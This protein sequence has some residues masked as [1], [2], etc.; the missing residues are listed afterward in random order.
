MIIVNVLEQSRTIQNLLGLEHSRT[1][2]KSLVILQEPINI[3]IQFFSNQFESTPVLSSHR[4]SCIH[5]YS[6]LIHSFFLL[7][8][9]HSFSRDLF[10]SFFYHFIFSLGSDNKTI[11]GW[12]SEKKT[13]NS[14]STDRDRFKDVRIHPDEPAGFG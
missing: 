6:T 13:M 12:E 14:G 9:F 4:L 10:M 2:Q 11:A 7:L 8:S 1:L 3:D 5:S